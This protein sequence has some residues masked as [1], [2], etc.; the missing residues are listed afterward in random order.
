M[1]AIQPNLVSILLRWAREVEGDQIAFYFSDSVAPVDRARNQIVNFFLGNHARFTHL[2]FIDSDTV[3]P[4]DAF[5]RLLSHEKPIVSGLTPILNLN[6]ETGRWETYDNCFR[7]RVSGP[8]GKIVTHIAERFTGLQEVFR[9]GSSCILIA[10]E[11]FERLVPQHAPFYAFECND[12]GTEHKRSEDIRFCDMAREVG[13]KI[14]ADT[15]VICQHHK[16]AVI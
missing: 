13:F 11:V 7:Q 12:D 9:C 8:D 4:P 16:K 2:L 6:K 10:R 14:Y 15:E 3:P 5:H 1:G